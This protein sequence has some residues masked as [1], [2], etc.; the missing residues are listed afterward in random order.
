MWFAGQGLGNRNNSLQAP[1]N[2]IFLP[3]LGFAWNPGGSTVIR[4]GFGV[5]AFT[6]SLDTYGAG[7]GFGS[8]ST[9][10]ASDGDNNVSPITIL[11]GPGTNAQTGAPLPYLSASKSPSAYNKQNVPYNPYHTP[12]GTMK[13]WS[14]GV[15]RQLGSNMAASIAYIGSHGSNLLT[16]R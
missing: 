8:N 11:S 16:S 13:Q 5:Y 2:S 9:G 12:V 4:G 14:L 6:W 7:N 10:N 3:R 1:L 15:E